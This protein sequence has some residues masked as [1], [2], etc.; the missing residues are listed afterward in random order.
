[1]KLYKVVNTI[2]KIIFGVFLI[3]VFCVMSGFGY[4][5]HLHKEM[6]K[7]D[8]IFLGESWYTY[9]ESTLM[10]YEM[11]H[12]GKHM[13]DDIKNRRYSPEEALS[14]LEFLGLSIQKM[15]SIAGDTLWRVPTD[16]L[17]NEAKSY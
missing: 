4:I 15:D 13:I 9:R 16:T 10:L 17:V 8:D 11:R 1:M 5:V 12:A 7:L 6:I 3:I 2:R 14:N